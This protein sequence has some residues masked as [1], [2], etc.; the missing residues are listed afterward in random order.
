M[1]GAAFLVYRLVSGVGSLVLGSGRLAV[2][3]FLA[4]SIAVAVVVYLVLVVV[5]RAVT[6]E[7]M[8]LVPKGDKLARALRL[9]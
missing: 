5:L 4:V 8:R 1:A 6:A 2:A 7:D 3:A 9:K